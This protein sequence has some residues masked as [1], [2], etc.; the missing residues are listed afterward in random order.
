[1][2]LNLKLITENY[3]IIPK[4]LKINQKPSKH[5]IDQKSQQKLKYI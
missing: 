3:Q 1:M 4:Y 2:K 5:F